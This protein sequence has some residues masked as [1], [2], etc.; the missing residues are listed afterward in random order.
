MFA[1]R[2]KNSIFILPKLTY[3]KPMKQSALEAFINFFMKHSE[4]IFGSIFGIGAKLAI[5][6]RSRRL[7]F[8]ETIGKIVIGLACGIIAFNYCAVYKVGEGAKVIVP[9][10]TMLGESIIFILMK[11][12]SPILRSIVMRNTG[13]EKEDWKDD[14]KS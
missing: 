4:I 14:T 6:S 2:D 3:K 12:I 7:S 5:D 9:I 13:I 10:A 8:F 1:M 11:N